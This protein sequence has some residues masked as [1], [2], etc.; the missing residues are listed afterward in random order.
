MGTLL[1]LIGVFGVNSSIAR[2]A[3][4]KKDL[5]QDKEYGGVYFWLPNS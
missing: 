2:Y 4:E 5:F 1:D 3:D